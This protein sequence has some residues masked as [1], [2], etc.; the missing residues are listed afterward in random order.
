M[1]GVEAIHEDPMEI[2][3]TLRITDDQDD[4]LNQLVESGEFPTRSAA[5]REAIDRMLEGEP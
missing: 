4:D 2:R 1:R 3:E 5:I